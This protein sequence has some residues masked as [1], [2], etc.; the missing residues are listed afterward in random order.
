MIT[1][2]FF[3]LCCKAGQQIDTWTDRSN[4]QDMNLM[5]GTCKCYLDAGPSREI[6]FSTNG[7]ICKTGAC[8]IVYKLRQFKL[9]KN[10][11]LKSN[12]NLFIK[13][14]QVQPLFS[15]CLLTVCLLQ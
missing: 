14:L 2:F 11:I 8:N 9:P 13:F 6:N 1:G 7:Q 3:T 15:Q 10:S 4:Q 5:K 12:Y